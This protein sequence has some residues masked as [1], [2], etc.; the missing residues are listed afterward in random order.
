MLDFLKVYGPI[1]A[2]V[3]I[4]FVAAYQFVDPAPPRSLTIATGNPD[5]AYYA[6]GKRYQDILGR[7]GINVT[8]VTT[9]GS[10]EN[11]AL[12]DRSPPED[13]AEP[14]IDIAFV[15]SGVGSPANF[16]GLVSLASLY[17]EP[18]WIFSRSQSMPHHLTEFSGKRLAIGPE[19]SGTRHVALQL[20]TANSV[21]HGDDHGTSMVD[22]GG[23]AAAEAL[24]AGQVDAAF[25][26]IAK[27]NPVLEELYARPDI[28][29]MSFDRADAYTRRYRY[30]SSVLLP[31]GIVDLANNVPEEDVILLSPV[32]TLVARE[33]VH[34]ALVDLVMRAATQI[35][36]GAG[37]FE[38]PSQF[39]SPLNVDFPLSPEA[40]RYF[41]SGLRFLR[42][43]MPFWAA[44]MV[45]RLWVMILPI[46]TLMIPL[47]RIAPPTYRWQVRRRIVR[48][49]R[50]LQ[51]L[52]ATLQMAV[53][54]SDEA[55][56]EDT[57]AALDRLQNE[58]GSVSVPLSYAD[59]LYTLRLHMDFV[60]RR[61]ARL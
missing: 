11:L 10:V 29:L 46:L 7:H 53:K 37:V 61:F 58:V 2:L 20:L 33:D 5:G 52:E 49:Y 34:P 51:S 12:L 8:L 19:G 42:R 4:G 18:L 23:A 9:A 32:A 35:H 43:I 30:L 21:I 57:L 22:L 28:H 6:F 40:E 31:E 25:F 54:A 44:T 56:R 55:A 45:E 3:I 1:V 47:L 16:P 15:Q 27:R 50:D 26:V 24:V 39:P 38:E 60:R 48:W 17:F 13:S 36:G 14:R 59:D 41:E